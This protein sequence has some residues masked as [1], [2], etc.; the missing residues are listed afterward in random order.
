[1]NLILFGK[2]LIF[3]LK[4]EIIYKSVNP[5]SRITICT[6]IIYTYKSLIVNLCIINLGLV[7]LNNKKKEIGKAY[8]CKNAYKKR[9]EIKNKKINAK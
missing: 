4:M 3:F 2:N 5:F 6:I 9:Q 8:F 7:T 1:M